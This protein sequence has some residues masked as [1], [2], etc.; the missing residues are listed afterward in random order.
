MPEDRAQ[1]LFFQLA[2]AVR[3]IHERNIAHRDIKLEN[4]LLDESLNV[5]LGDFGFSVVAAPDALVRTPCGSPFYAAPEVIDNKEY[6]GRK[7]DIWSLGICLYV[8]CVGKF[9]WDADSRLTLYTQIVQTNV[10][11][12]GFLSFELRKLLTFML[13]RNPE[14]RITIDQALRAEWL[15]DVR[16]A[17]M[18]T[19]RR[20]APAPQTRISPSSSMPPIR[21]TMHGHARSVLN[22]FRKDRRKR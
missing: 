17:Q 2:S 4:V 6:V 8:M 11:P 3:Y 22:G 7:A 1:E 19:R 10:R 14:T 16:D 18:S 15:T 21:L 5:H 20:P 12:P 9:P 13:D